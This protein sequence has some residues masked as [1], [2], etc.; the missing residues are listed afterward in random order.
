MHDLKCETLYHLI[1]ETLKTLKNLRGKLS[2]R[3]VSYVL[4]TFITFGMSTSHILGTS[5]SEMLW[6]IEIVP[7]L[8]G[9]L[10]M[11]ASA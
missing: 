2:V 1:L 6:Q 3:L 11:A 9:D 4:I 8:E 10:T 5:H 7:V